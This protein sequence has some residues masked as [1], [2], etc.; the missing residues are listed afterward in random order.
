MSKLKL[1]KIDAGDCRL[2]R[3]TEKAWKAIKKANAPPY[4]F[5]YG[6]APCRLERDDGGVLGIQHLTP[7]KLRYEAA[8]AA[9][10]FKLGEGTKR[11]PAKPPKD[12]IQDMLAAPTLPLPI[13]ERITQVPVFSSG[14]AI[15]TEPGYF[16]EAKIYYAPPRGL[17]IEKVPSSPTQ[18]DIARAKKLIFGDLFHDFPFQESADLAHATA[19][20]LHPFSRGLILGP[21]PLHVPRSPIA[22]CGKTLLSIACL[23]PALGYRFTVMAQTKSE[24]EQRKR[25]TAAL[26]QGAGAI[27]ID[28]IQRRLD[29]SSLAAALTLPF[30]ADRILGQSAMVNLPVRC[31]WIVTGNNIELSREFARRSIP[32]SLDPQCSRPWERQGF[33]HPN[34]LEFVDKHRG[35]LVW[36]ALVLVQN[37]IVLGK[38]L[39][40]EKTLGSFERWA[41]VMGGILEVNGV[42][43]FLGNLDSFYQAADTESERWELFVLK[44]WEKFHQK[45]VGAGELFQL[46][47]ESDIELSGNNHQGLLTSFGVQLRDHRDQVI[48]QFKIIR[49]GQS[50]RAIQWSLKPAHI[51]TVKNVGSGGDGQYASINPDDFEK[52]DILTRESTDFD[53]GSYSENRRGASL[54]PDDF[55]KAH[56]Q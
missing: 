31:A 49:A 47:L 8:R 38:P 26:M 55:E 11:Y 13:L 12:V 41:A 45:S 17:T 36:S 40:K 9:E 18:T 5:R 6:N 46:A 28:N 24:D 48:G 16:P 37:W 56:A 20:F 21:T 14:G 15:L 50:N 19:L 39:W 29:S 35:A 7:D 1:P 43:G 52:D 34:L 25:I 33:K 3:V 27:V 32:I 44:W 2:S 42:E 23:R 54:D 51:K 4:L 22:G 10:W 30:W 53:E